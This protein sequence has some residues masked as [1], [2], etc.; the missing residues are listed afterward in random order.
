LDTSVIIRRETLRIYWM[1]KYL[2]SPKSMRL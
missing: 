2:F 1:L